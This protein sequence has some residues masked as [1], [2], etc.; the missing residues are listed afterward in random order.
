MAAFWGSDGTAAVGDS[1]C[2]E[3][4]LHIALNALSC[5]VD[6]AGGGACVHDSDDDRGRVVPQDACRHTHCGDGGV[7]VA[8]SNHVA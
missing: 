4:L 5:P 7:P 1:Q 2:C 6:K 3:R 8:R